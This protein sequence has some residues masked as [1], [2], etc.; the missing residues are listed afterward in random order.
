MVK[1]IYSQALERHGGSGV[2]KPQ[3][4]LQLGVDWL[5][6]S[7]FENSRG[8]VCSGSYADRKGITP[9][10]VTSQMLEWSQEQ[11]ERH[12]YSLPR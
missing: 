1:M 2:C 3:R 10:R 11:K 4:R 12:V 7:L 5:A 6:G 8:G 9:I